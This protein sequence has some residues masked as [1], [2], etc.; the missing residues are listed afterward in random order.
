[1]FYPS[2]GSGAGMS[3]R[4]SAA[5]LAELWSS[6]PTVQPLLGPSLCA[7]ADNVY[8]DMGTN[9]G[10]HILMFYQP[11]RFGYIG[12]YR[13]WFGSCGWADKH[14]K[15]KVC[16]NETVVRERLVSACVMSFEPSPM[17]Q[18]NLQGR[19]QQYRADGARR[20]HFFS[21]AI[22]AHN[23]VETF[24]FTPG[25][26]HDTGASLARSSSLISTETRRNASAVPTVSLAW[27]LK[28]HVP[29]SARVFSKMDIEGAEYTA[30]LPAIPQLCKYVDA[31][32][33]ELHDKH[34]KM[35]RQALAQRADAA[36]TAAV[37]A[38]QGALQQSKALHGALAALEANRTAGKC[39]TR[40]KLLSAS[41]T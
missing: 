24:H 36:G 16:E 23:S 11:R 2:A 1:M 32:L 4:A 15:A 40:V 35:T 19:F 10:K 12:E 7:G 31:M 37:Q 33:L 14:N 8:I 26:G 9:M 30:L 34:L 21:A 6:F 5:N 18:P 20:L 41:N 28:R 25:K 3:S 38:A 39:R 27:L 22:A 17:H 29:R 13:N